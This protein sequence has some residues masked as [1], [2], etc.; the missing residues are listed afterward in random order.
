MQP[1]KITHIR[2]IRHTFF[3][4]KTKLSHEISILCAANACFCLLS[5]G[6]HKRDEGER[7]LS[8][9]K[10][11]EMIVLQSSLTISENNLVQF[12]WIKLYLEHLGR[13]LL[14]HKQKN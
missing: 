6:S 10:K 13:P 2:P 11:S 8:K 7:I 3:V 5:Q 4:R 1:C 12:G 14:D 9:I